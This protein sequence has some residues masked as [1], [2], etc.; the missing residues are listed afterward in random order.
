MFWEVAVS[1]LTWRRAS[2]FLYPWMSLS[3]SL[4][5]MERILALSA[6]PR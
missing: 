2:I 6:T 1:F 3:I 5:L 4:I